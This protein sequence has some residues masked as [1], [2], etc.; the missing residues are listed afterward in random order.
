MKLL[1]I[2]IT[3]NNLVL[4]FLQVL[5]ARV[6]LPLQLDYRTMEKTFQKCGTSRG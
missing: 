2:A 6:S 4:G 3:V 1:G 5:L